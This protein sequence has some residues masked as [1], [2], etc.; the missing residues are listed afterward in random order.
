M[1]GDLLEIPL[2]RDVLWCYSIYVCQS[3]SCSGAS[4]PA[5]IW[6]LLYITGLPLMP[7]CE[8]KAQFCPF[9]CFPPT[10]HLFICFPLSTGDFQ[11]LIAK[12]GLAWDSGGACWSQSGWLKHMLAVSFLTPH[13]NGKQAHC[14]A[15]FSKRA[16]MNF[17]Q[18]AHLY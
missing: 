15:P 9:Q 3:N 4:F 1:P 14:Q 5:M 16:L 17:K 2:A 10:W 6:G 13:A 11:V 18:S 7:A 8:H 12:A